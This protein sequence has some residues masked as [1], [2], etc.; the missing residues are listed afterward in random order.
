MQ[1][2]EFGSIQYSVG[3]E[4]YAVMFQAVF[5]SVIFRFTAIVVDLE[6]GI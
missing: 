5:L 4:C 1:L 6:I 3:I 2:F